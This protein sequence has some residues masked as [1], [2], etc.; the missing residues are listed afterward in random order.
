MRQLMR[1]IMM[2]TTKEKIQ[3]LIKKAI[4][5]LQAEKKLPA[6]KIPEILV[7]KSERKEH[8]DYATNIAMVIAKEAKKKPM[9]IAEALKSKI[10]KDP[11][12]S[13]RE[14][15]SKTKTK[16]KK[17]NIIEK[18]EIEEPGFV[19]FFLSSDYLQKQ[20]K[21]VLKKEEDFGSVNLGRGK[22]LQV[23]F[24]SANPT[25]P[26]TV[27]NARGGPF[28]DALGNILEMAGWKV[29]RAYY[30]NDYG[31]QIIALGHSVLKDKNAQY[32][33][34]YIDKLHR[35]IQERDVYKAGQRAAREIMKMIKK[36]TDRLGIKYNEWIWESKFYQSSAVEKV[37]DFLKKKKLIYQ[38][39]GALW[40]R[41][42]KF[43]DK[44]DRVVV[45]K[46][47]S[48]TYLAGDIALHQY[49][50]EKKKFQKVI[51]IW[52]ADHQGDVPGL[53]AAVTALGH[54]GK[55]DIILLQFVTILKKGKPLKMSKRRG[56]FLTMD[57]LLDEVGLDVVR[58]FFLQKS[59]NT[60]LHFD[61]DLAKEQ[62]E[63]NPVY[64]VQYAYARSC[65]IIKKS[66][67]KKQKLKGEIKNARIELLG[68]PSE[69]NLIKQ[70]IRLPEI[71]E[72]TARDYQ[73][74]RLC[75]YALDLATA[76][77]QFYRDCKVLVKD[78]ELQKARL[79][80]I[81]ATRAVL[82]KTLRLMGISAPERM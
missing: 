53:Q 18:I 54:R 6:F 47:G 66:K 59:A 21:E 76:F 56:V 12:G 74:Q 2:M 79:A 49:K 16:N 23:E 13:L 30:V 37:L 7:A 9:E 64:Y 42:S 43:G 17:I 34:D 69:L 32:K 81:L 73:V 4:K 77:H 11:T 41:S 50:F 62:S 20:V 25:G 61:L 67:I 38:K 44:R 5:E 39:E 35:K 29:E 14:Q 31:Q 26:L 48:K 65:S 19:N 28:G 80:L 68:Y 10:K 57:E 70:L 22:K 45:K 75:Q 78:V 3:N 82:K 71:V 8:G 24:I 72:D 51:N 46:D 36:T 15:K 33:G 60:H 58:F 1:T 52:G 27:G 40:F 63:K 55:L